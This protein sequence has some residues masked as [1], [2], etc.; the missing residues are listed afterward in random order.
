MVYIIILFDRENLCFHSLFIRLI[1]I[2]M[3]F[4]RKN[5]FFHALFIITLFSSLQAG[6]HSI[7]PNHLALEI[8]KCR[9]DSCYYCTRR[10]A[11]GRPNL[12]WRYFNINWG[13]ILMRWTTYC[14][15]H[16]QH[17]SVWVR[18]QECLAWQPPDTFTVFCS[19]PCMWVLGSVVL[20]KR[21]KT[22]HCF[23]GPP[24]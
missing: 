22:G 18:P 8:P 14:R 20:G 19:F 6:V 7:L 16:K 13:M 9:L 15:W 1:F 24:Q 21:W 4:D 10:V 12:L 11:L 5:V 23:N 3:L 17:I 2:V